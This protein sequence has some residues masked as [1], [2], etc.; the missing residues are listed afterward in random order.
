MNVDGTT[1]QLQECSV[2]DGV[3]YEVDSGQVI[4]DT[5]VTRSVEA[6]MEQVDG[7]WK[8]AA[9]RVVQSWEGVAGCAL[10]A[11]F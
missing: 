1:A 10:S 4:D 5:V 11:D 3:V 7:V 8:L 9:T 2:N 6:T